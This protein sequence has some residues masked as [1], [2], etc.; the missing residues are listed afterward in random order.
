MENKKEVIDS[1]SIVMTTDTG[2]KITIDLNDI[3]DDLAEEID[4]FIENELKYRVTWREYGEK[5][6]QSKF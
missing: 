4:S 6:E 5:E 2:G 1:W 3:H